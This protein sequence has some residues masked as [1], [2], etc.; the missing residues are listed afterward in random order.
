MVDDIEVGQ[1][2]SESGVK[3]NIILNIVHKYIV[4]ILKSFK[5]INLQQKQKQTCS[6]QSELA[7]S[8]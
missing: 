2:G 5:G 4:Q 1:S 3:Y 8:C 7:V 6:H